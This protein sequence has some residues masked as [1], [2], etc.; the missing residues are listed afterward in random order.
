MRFAALH[1]ATGTALIAK[2]ARTIGDGAD[3]YWVLPNTTQMAFTHFNSGQI[4]SIGGATGSIAHN[5]TLAINT[6]YCFAIERQGNTLN[7][8]ADGTRIY[9]NTTFF[10]AVPYVLNGRFVG[11]ST[12]YA[13]PVTVGR[14]YSVGSVAR[15]R[16]MD[17]WIDGVYIEKR[18]VIGGAASYTVP[19]AARTIKQG[20]DS[21]LRLLWDCEKQRPTTCARAW[22]GCLVHR[23]PARGP[24]SEPTSL[25]MAHAAWFAYITPSRGWWPLGDSDFTFDCWFNL[26]V[27]PTRGGIAFG[28]S[29][30][31]TGNRRGWRF[32]LERHRRRAGI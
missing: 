20:Q 8:Y 22:C 5:L 30:R 25:R 14:L 16:A 23:F 2:Y 19:T 9:Q 10:D 24:S 13:R 11:P 32:R 12:Y 31:E 15:M 18:A 7:M 3:W 21:P 6:W 4:A 1:P 26:D 27:V 17:G 29:W 28:N